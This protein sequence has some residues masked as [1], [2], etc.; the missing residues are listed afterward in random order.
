MLLLLP[1]LVL[2]LTPVT[3][4][5][6]Y[7][8]CSNKTYTPNS[9]FENNLK[10]LLWSLSSNTNLTGFNSTS[11]G[12]NINQVH[13]RA[14]CRG[15]VAAKDC[16]NCV[17]NASQ[18]IMKVCKSEEAIIWYEFCQV[19]YSYQM[20]SVKV[21]TGKY[22]DSNSQKKNVSD[23]GHFYSVLKGL[24]RNLTN[25]AAFDH[26]KLMF[27][28]G[29]TKLLWN[30]TIYGL[31]Q[32]TRDQP[33]GFCSNCLTS[34]FGDLSGCS[35][36]HEDRTILRSCNMRFEVYRF[37]KVP[38]VHGE[39]KLWMLVLVICIPTFAL[40]VLIGSCILYCQERKATQNDEEKSQHTL[41]HELAT[42]TT[43]AMIQEGSLLL[44]Q[45]LP[46]MDL[47]TEFK[48]E[49]I[50][51]GKLQ[52][53]KLVRL[54]G[55][56]IGGDEKLLIYEFM[57]NKS[58]DIFIFDL[59]LGL[60]ILDE[61]KGSQLNWETRHNIINGIAGGLLYLREDSRLKII[62]RDLNGYMAPLYAMERI[63]S[64]KSDVFSFG[65]LLLEIISGKRNSL[66][67]HT[68]CSDTPSMCRIVN[69]QAWWLWNE[70]KE[71]EL[72]DSLLTESCPAEEILRCVH[73]GL[74]CV[75]ED[76]ADRPTMSSV[77]V[78]LES[79][80]VSLRE[81]KQ[82]AFSVGRGVQFDQ[83]PSSNPSTNQ[84]TV[85]GISPR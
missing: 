32:C 10:G 11:V 20:F 45:E 81:P 55:C 40:A 66:L 84:L 72:V 36:T 15:D 67:P 42:P 64:V 24:M 41:V 31:V 29:E 47:A 83:S 77:V 7:K 74:L 68:T 35:K 21:Y 61:E 56:G 75:Q 76:P 59:Y 43:I 27:A 71:L 5:P 52:H 9:P 22:P 57:P 85:S 73:I 12:S 49:I 16:K 54:L 50:L 1:S 65:V 33:G 62:H 51:I 30:L 37:Y 18:E 26:A 28:V 46:F 82:P 63:F 23:P 70:G 4:D 25:D 80:S 60:L 79:K 39:W 3:G 19:Q 69:G 44:P 14:L 78:L 53:R 2:L 48:N 34:A 8:V 38:T 6:L 17:E 13:G 58:L